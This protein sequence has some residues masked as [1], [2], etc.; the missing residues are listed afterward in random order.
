[1]SGSA[2]STATDQRRRERYVATAWPSV[3]RFAFA[4]WLGRGYAVD[5]PRW[6]FVSPGNLLAL[7]TVPLGAGLYLAKFLPFVSRRYVLSDRRVGVAHGLRQRLVESVAHD[8]YDAI[9]VEILSGQAWYDAG[10]LVFRRDGRPVLRLASVVSP[11]MFRRTIWETRQAH[12]L[13]RPLLDDRQDAPAA[14]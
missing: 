9:E 10:D 7:A 8:A 2:E 13:L 11:E 6:S 1:M 4:R 14:A 12:L 5:R 3:A